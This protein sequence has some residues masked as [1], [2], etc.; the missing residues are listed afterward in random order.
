[1][2]LLNYVQAEVLHK[3]VCV[4]VCVIFLYKAHLWGREHKI[5][6]QWK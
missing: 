1:M 3:S 4:C 2:C 6:V 5:G